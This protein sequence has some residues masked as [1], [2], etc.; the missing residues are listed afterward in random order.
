MRRIVAGLA[1]LALLL[2]ATGVVWAGW[3]HCAP[4]CAVTYQYQT[5][6]QPVKRVVYRCVPVTTEH[7]V[8]VTS[9]GGNTRRR[10]SLSARSDA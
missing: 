4:A 3:G 5:T 1:A 10:R 8:T 9:A 2:Q 6:Y 7:E